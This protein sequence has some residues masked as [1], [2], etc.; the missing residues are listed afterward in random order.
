MLNYIYIATS[1]WTINKLLPDM[2]NYLYITTWYVEL[3]IYITTW[4]VELYIYYYL[5][6]WTIY[7]LLPDILNYIYI[8]CYLICWTIYIYY[9]LICWTLY[10]YIATWYVELYIYY[11]LICWA[12]YI[13]LLDMLNYIYIL[14]PDMLNQLMVTGEGFETLLT[15]MR[16]NFRSPYSFSSQLHS[17]L[18][19]QILKKKLNFLVFLFSRLTLYLDLLILITPIVLLFLSIRWV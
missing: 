15:L 3:Y 1:C 11:Y 19:H 18:C 6:C 16:F 7:I 4:Y 17:S 14:V 5:I 13:L 2:L 12:L 8:Y 10:M 9:Y